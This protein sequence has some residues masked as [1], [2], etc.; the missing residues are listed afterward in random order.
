MPTSHTDV[1]SSLISLVIKQKKAARIMN[2]CKYDDHSSSIFN[3]FDLPITGC[4]SQFHN[5]P[6]QHIFWSLDH[7]SLNSLL[8]NNTNPFWKD[9]MESWGAYLS[10]E[11]EAIHIHRPLWN[12]YFIKIEN[13]PF[14]CKPWIDTVILYINVLIDNNGICFKSCIEFY[15]KNNFCGSFI[16]YHSILSAIPKPWIKT[17]KEN[18]NIDVH[19]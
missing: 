13:E 10:N 4:M 18:L 8:R 17:L 3:A 7:L 11:Q 16:N 12:G 9:V 6:L 14:Y 5:K 2:F 1:G 19:L 15:Q